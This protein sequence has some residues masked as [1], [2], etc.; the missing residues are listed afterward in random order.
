MANFL[1]SERVS[2]DCAGQ[3]SALLSFTSHIYTSISA[4]LCQAGARTT[5]GRGV[6]RA[7]YCSQNVSY[8]EKVVCRSEDIGEIG[9]A[10]H[11]TFG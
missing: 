6:P 4:A 1:L 8:K 7:R 2:A 11:S 9:C 5:G 3:K 10:L